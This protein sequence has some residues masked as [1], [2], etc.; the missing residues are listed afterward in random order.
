MVARVFLA[1][2][3]PI[4]VA[5]GWAFVFAPHPT[6]FLALLA[7]PLGYLLACWAAGPV[8]ALAKSAV[9]LEKGEYTHRVAPDGG[10]ECERIARSFN[11]MSARLAAGF[12]QLENDREQLRTILGG[13]VEGV[14]ALDPEQV[15][16]F[17]ND[18]A[19]QL[20]E[21]APEAAV[22]RKLYEAT[23]QKLILEIVEKALAGRGPH[24]QELEYTGPV[25][26]FLAVYVSPLPGDAPLGAIL[27]IHDI[28]ELRRLERL[29]QDFV[30]NVSHELKTPL[31]VIRSNI[32]AL[33]DGAAE[34][35]EARGPFLERVRL[36]ADRLDALIQD[37][38]RLARIESGEQL[39]DPEPLNFAEAVQDCLERHGAR[40]EEKT[41]RVIEIPP[42]DLSLKVL[43]DGAG[44]DQILDNLVDNA[45][46]YTL[47]G[48]KITV[49]WGPAGAG[50]LSVSVADTGPGI[51][52]RDLPRVFERFYRVDKARSRLVGGTGL[53]LAIVKH[54]VQAMNGTVTAASEE[55]K[56][57]TFT[58]TLPKA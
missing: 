10:P 41:L 13:M 32:E 17:A 29:R 11:A 37:L 16:L 18:R 45:I 51:P 50:Q 2:S 36:E 20:L 23:R 14:I 53:G 42:P 9:R 35:P 31:A 8:R 43:A 30:A 38:L 19:G 28:T 7:L 4:L 5:A 58:V 55:G 57:T 12:T 21:F 25:P 27:V 47:P 39:V 3:V 22:G 52:K 1:C 54:L 6:A 46:K 24:R 48:G 40:A 15:V 56:G 44:L 33:Q 26:R 34:D 49:R